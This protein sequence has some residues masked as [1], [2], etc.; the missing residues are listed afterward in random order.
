MTRPRREIVSVQD[1]PYYHV[2]SRC[3]RRTYLCGIADY[4]KIDGIYV[5]NMADSEVEHVIVKAI[6]DFGQVMGIATNAKFVENDEIRDL[7]ARVGVNY[8]QGNIIGQPLPLS[9]LLRRSGTIFNM[10]RI[11]SQLRQIH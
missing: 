8:A 10:R 5:E 7:L 3:V 1:T 9:E 6:N 2:V 11:G 4:L